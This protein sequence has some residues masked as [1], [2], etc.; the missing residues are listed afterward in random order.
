MASVLKKFCITLT[1]HPTNATHHMVVDAN[2][3]SIV[4]ALAEA[5]ICKMPTRIAFDYGTEQEV[6]THWW[7]T[8]EEIPCVN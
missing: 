7:S 3:A 8:I 5:V 4:E 2:D 6:E 1:E